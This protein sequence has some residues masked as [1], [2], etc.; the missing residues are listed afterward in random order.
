MSLSHVIKSKTFSDDLAFDG[1]LFSLSVFLKSLPV[2]F[3]KGS[4]FNPSFNLFKRDGKHSVQVHLNKLECHG[5]VHL[6]Q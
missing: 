3:S 2:L 4:K 5:K 6:F 1:V